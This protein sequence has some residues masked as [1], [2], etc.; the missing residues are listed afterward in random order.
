LEGIRAAEAEI[1][2]G[3]TFDEATI[4]KDMTARRASSS[5]DE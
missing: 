4:R 2:R 1:A 3:E 5:A